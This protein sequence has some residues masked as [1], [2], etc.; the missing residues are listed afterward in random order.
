MIATR[1]VFFVLTVYGCVYLGGIDMACADPANEEIAIAQEKKEAADCYF[2][3]T[4]KKADRA[5]LIQSLS[6]TNAQGQKAVEVATALDLIRLSAEKSP[7]LARNVEACYQQNPYWLVQVKCVET[8]SVLDEAR[9]D[10]LA[11]RI[12]DD[13]NIELEARLLVAKLE[14][15]KGKIFGYPVLREG[16]MSTNGYQQRI[17]AELMNEFEKYDG[18][19][20]DKANGKID[21]QKLR[22]E[23]VA[24]PR[25]VD[26]LH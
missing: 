3:M 6:I 10:D 2:I 12:L 13:S 16:L 24:P 26:A 15:K 22:N 17:A 5:N 21:I 11:H 1:F 7:E 20:Y 19:V 25:K 14:L 18:L 8:L 9:A 23:C 4:G